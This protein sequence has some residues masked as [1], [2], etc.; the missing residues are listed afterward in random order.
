MDKLGSVGILADI[1]DCL[2]SAEILADINDC[3]ESAGILGGHIFGEYVREVIVPR[4]NDSQCRINVNNIDI[5]FKTRDQANYFIDHVLGLKLERLDHITD[6]LYIPPYERFNLIKAGTKIATLNVYISP[7]FS[8]LYF[9]IENITFKYVD[10]SLVAKSRCNRN[11]EQL[12]CYI[13]NKQVMVPKEFI[14]KLNQYSEHYSRLLYDQ[15]LGLGYQ[16]I[17]E[18]TLSSNMLNLLSNQ[19]SLTVHVNIE[20]VK[21]CDP[22]NANISFSYQNVNDDTKM[23][24]YLT[25]TNPLMIL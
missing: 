22:I 19:N 14:S 5:W 6:S 25:S 17:C 18:D 11:I 16:L 23:I 12:K 13:L 20:Y 10:G 3:L 8:K 15:F 9:G 7:E 24:V 2:E 4:R 21:N 1:N